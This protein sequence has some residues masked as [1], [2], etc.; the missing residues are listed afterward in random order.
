MPV[1]VR[2][3]KEDGVGYKLGIRKGDLLIR[4]N[5]EDVKDFLEFK[6]LISD[7]DVFLE[8]ESR[9]GVRRSMRVKKEWDDD[10]GI[11]VEVRYRRCRN[12][13][14]FCFVDQLP[15]GLRRTLYF[16]DDDYRLS[17][18]YGNYITLTDLDEED[19]RR[20]R[21]RR[22]S[23]IYVSVHATNPR[24]R[25]FMLSG[26]EDPDR[27]LVERADIIPKL[28]S[29]SEARIELHAQIVLCPG[30]NDGEELE[31]TVSDLSE[32]PM[33]KTVALVPVGLTDHRD[34]LY[35][36]NPVTPEYARRVVRW[37]KG[38]Q[39]EFLR[40]IGRRFLFLSDEFYLISGEELPPLAHYEDLAQVE[41]GVGMTRVF[42]E[43]FSRAIRRIP[44]RSKAKAR[45]SIV[46]GLLAFPILKKYVVWRLRKVEGLKLDLIAVENKF[47]G[48][49]ITVAGLLTGRDI[50]EALSGRDLGDLVLV[51]GEALNQDGLFL[52]DIRLGDMERELGVPVESGGRS[53]SSL[54]EA[55]SRVVRGWSR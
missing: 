28:R 11:D 54:A 40:R 1:R 18:L 45:I 7:E 13:C 3:I 10:L 39:R 53:G 2:E 5:G 29:L 52:D 50:L 19:L 38:R 41:N 47:L 12:K 9:D 23:P 30:I 37:A 4:I 6:Y 35:P 55:I 51:P 36:L 31:R 44:G 25:A 46:T 43:E 15:K 20:I 21:E 17:F 34:G 32:I 14:I 42:I 16:K 26:K 48:R 22:L 33:V 27:S 49:S 24:L 8:I